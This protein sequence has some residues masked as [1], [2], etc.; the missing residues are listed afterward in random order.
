MSM[1]STCG[2]FMSAD[3]SRQMPPEKRKKAVT[4]AADLRRSPS[5]PLTGRWRCRS[6]AI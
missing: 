6:D 2:L 4:L 5:N 3:L 1:L